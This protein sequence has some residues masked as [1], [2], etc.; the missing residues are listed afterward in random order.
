[1][2]RT[3]NV[4][5][6][7]KWLCFC[8]FILLTYLPTI[9]AVSELDKKVKEELEKSFLSL[10]PFWRKNFR[11]GWL[12]PGW[13]RSRW[14]RPSQPSRRTARR[15]DWGT[16]ASRSPCSWRA[17]STRRM[18]SSRILPSSSRA[19]R[20]CTGL[21][22]HE[23]IIHQSFSRFLISKKKKLFLIWIS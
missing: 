18:A 6:N 13:P 11:L 4:H 2:Y 22:S 9:A 3:N 14:A 7:V 16:W 17:P 15:A 23:F 12:C 8:S 1:M 19:R 21:S 10:L 20:T 5:A